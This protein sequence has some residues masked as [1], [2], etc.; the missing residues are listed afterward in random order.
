MPIVEAQEVNGS[1]AIDIAKVVAEM[2][3][4]NDDQLIRNVELFGPVNNETVTI[5]VQVHNRLK[6]LKLLID[7][8]SKVFYRREIRDQKQFF[9]ISLIKNYLALW[10]YLYRTNKISTGSN[11]SKQKPFTNLKRNVNKIFRPHS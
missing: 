5:V 3:K 4:I 10:L 9:F 1:I 6:Y 7:S 2:K 11:H 8:L